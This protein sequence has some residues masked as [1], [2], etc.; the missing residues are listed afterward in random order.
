M[1]LN[2]NKL[3]LIPVVISLLFFA[4]SVLKYFVKTSCDKCQLFLPHAFRLF[5]GGSGKGSS[6]YISANSLL[7]LGIQYIV[8]GRTEMTKKKENVN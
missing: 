4:D 3:K 2:I 8:M 1:T 7:I 6:E 5:F